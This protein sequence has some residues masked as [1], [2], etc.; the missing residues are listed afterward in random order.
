[1]ASV[2]KKDGRTKLWFRFKDEA[3]EWKSAPTPY[4][5]DQEEE[6]ERYAEAAQRVIDDR[7]AAGANAAPVPLTVRAWADKWIEDR[8]D[9][10]WKND[11]SRLR[12]HV[13]PTLGDR[14]LADVRAPHLVELFKKLRKGEER[15]LAPRT[16][17][18]VYGVVA[19]LFRDAVIAD[20]V[21]QTPCVLDERHLGQ[22]EDVDPQW[23]EQALFTRDEVE[24]LIVDPRIPE[25]RQMVYALGS[26]GGL[27]HGELAGL[28][29]HRYDAAVRP[30]GALVVATSY[31][32]GKTKTGA[33]RRFPVH[34][35]LAAMLARWKL[36]GWA[37]MMGRDPK[38]EDL[39]VPMPPEDQAARRKN[40]DDP[41]R[42]KFYSWKRLCGHKKLVGDLQALGLRHRSGHDMR[43]TFIT[44]LLDD[45]ADPRIIETRVTHTRRSKSQSAFEGYNRGQQWEAV[46]REVAKLCI[47]RKPR[48]TI[49]ALGTA[50]GTADRRGDE[51]LSDS[52]GERRGS[53][54]RQP[55]PQRESA[56]AI[57]RDD[58]PS[59]QSDTDGAHPGASE[60]GDA[61]ARLATALEE[62]IRA[63]DLELA[64]ALVGDLRQLA[65]VRA[66]RGAG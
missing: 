40:R 61:V 47:S 43:A 38:P 16:V 42:D 59:A 11:E 26:I 24:Q 34:P 29:W 2:F 56:L 9:Q 25:D 57:V 6:A 35:V 23:R 49:T 53:N 17:H 5:L 30:L 15:K 63:G 28:R 41:M 36:G 39:I 1:M 44:L 48:G 46:C 19:A 45:G 20:L 55:G 54:P 18:N 10:D 52:W 58:A 21:E 3:G 37:R 4:G 66:A 8:K 31:D 12:L 22:V 62:A 14:L 27:R 7:V 33:I 51:M 60:P 64:L 65:A 32:K 50:R 13:L